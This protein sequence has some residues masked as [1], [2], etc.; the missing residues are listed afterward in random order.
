MGNLHW[1][2]ASWATAMDVPFGGL[3]TT[4]IPQH[5]MRK[6]DLLG[7]HCPN[8]FAR[9]VPEMGLFWKNLREADN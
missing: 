7:Y 8:Y 1:A 4:P 6:I 9:L 3:T 2:V 5:Q